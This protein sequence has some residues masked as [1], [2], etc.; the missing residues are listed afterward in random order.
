MDKLA[1][2]QQWRRPTTAPFPQN[3][4]KFESK[5]KNGKTYKIRIEDLTPNRYE[6]AS[7][8]ML[9]YFTNS[10]PILR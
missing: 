3:W 7:D 4:H 10:E 5:P 9:K 8:F 6:E 1:E 2:S